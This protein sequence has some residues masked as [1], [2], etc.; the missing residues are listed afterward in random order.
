[1]QPTTDIQNLQN[2]CSLLNLTLQL[3]EIKE[4]SGK[5]AELIA[6]VK[7]F[8]KS[9]HDQSMQALKQAE[10]QKAIADQEALDDAENEKEFVEYKKPESTQHE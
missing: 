8:L 4:W 10:I 3:I 9:L 2:S 7:A 5:D 1:M 6:Q